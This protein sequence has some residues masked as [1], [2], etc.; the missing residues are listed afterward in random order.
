[1]ENTTSTYTG[2]G[3]TNNNA[4]KV[5]SIVAA[6]DIKN[7]TKE[8]NF[9]LSVPKYNTKMSLG[10]TQDNSFSNDIDLCR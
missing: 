3:N 7:I 9:D 8:V 4:L 10:K 2:I 1:M 5:Q 6:Y